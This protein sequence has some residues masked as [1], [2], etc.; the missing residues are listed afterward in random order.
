[1][2]IN[3]NAQHLLLYHSIVHCVADTYLFNK[4]IHHWIWY[5]TNGCTR[6][7]IDHIPMSQHWCSV[8]SC[9]VFKCA[10]L[11][12]TDHW[13][14]TTCLR[15]KLKVERLVKGKPHSDVPCL[16]DPQIAATYT[17]QQIQHYCWRGSW[18]MKSFQRDNWSSTHRCAWNRC[19]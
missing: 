1:M 19:R 12:N 5:S 3:D 6:K 10:Q 18:W 13:L 16:K 2:P 14:L 17:C 4:N 8:T 15:I 9:R 11:G 7:A